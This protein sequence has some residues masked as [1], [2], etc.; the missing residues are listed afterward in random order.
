MSRGGGKGWYRSNKTAHLH[1]RRIIMRC[2]GIS[3]GRYGGSEVVVAG[4]EPPVREDGGISN[5]VQ[6][7]CKTT[8]HATEVGTVRSA[9]DAADVFVAS[10]DDGLCR[11]EA[12]DGFSKKQGVLRNMGENGTRHVQA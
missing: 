3:W 12:L 8:L 1:E 5:N 6:A 9:R 7:Y 2:R 4:A 11:A 10:A